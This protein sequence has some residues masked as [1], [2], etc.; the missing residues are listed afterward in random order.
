MYRLLNYNET[1]P[2]V[3]LNI[4]NRYKQLTK[5]LIRLFQNTESVNDIIKSLS[6]YLIEKNQE[7]ID[8]IDSA[9]LTFIINLVSKYGETLYNDQIWQE[10][11]IKYPDGEIQEKPYSWYIEG[12]GSVSKN[13]ITKTCETKFGAKPYRDSEKGRGLIFNQKILNKLIV[14]YSIIEGIKI[15]KEER[16]EKKRLYSSKF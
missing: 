5:P 9:I 12:Y 16:E 2:D 1:I 3:K 14:N 13:S 7:K 15:I 4:K 11:K 8:S 10:L 6:K